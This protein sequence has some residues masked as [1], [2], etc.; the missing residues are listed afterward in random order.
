MLRCLGLFTATLC[1]LFTIGFAVQALDPS[2]PKWKW[3]DDQIEEQFLPFQAQGITPEMLDLT[4]QKTPGFK[5]TD[6]IYVKR[7]QIIDGEIHG[8]DGDAR[9]FLSTLIQLYPLP[10]LDVI[11]YIQDMIWTPELL[12]CPVLAT[13]T[14]KNKTDKIIFFPLQ[15]INYW[16]D[17]SKI[18]NDISK[19]SPWEAKYP[20]VFWRGGMND[21]DNPYNK[22]EW[23]TTPRGKLCYLSKYFPQFIDA[24]FSNM[25]RLE[26]EGIKND[27][28]QL[29]PI[30]TTS[31]EEH[32]R[33]KY[34]I[35][36][37]G[38]VASTPGCA[39][40]LLSNCA[41]F[42]QDSPYLL[43]YFSQLQ[44]WVHYIPVAQNL[45]DLFL[46]I[47]WAREHDDEVRQIAENGRAFAQEN[48]MPEHL[49]LYCYK[50]LKKYASLQRTRSTTP[51]PPVAETPPAIPAP[52]PDVVPAPTTP[53]SP[54]ATPHQTNKK[55]EKK[56]KRK[57]NKHRK[58]MEIYF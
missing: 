22:A 30:E 47:E 46:K 7:H 4:M 1:C 36:L 27:F 2:D 17:F 19:N 43:W 26:G 9:D 6:Y 56:K 37:D 31:W 40:K 12:A 25:V 38:S 32:L 58:S 42:K 34:L 10:D 24:T 51:V 44:P 54:A 21:Y 14:I 35:D 8:P 20:V 16:E 45:S 49:Y 15:L 23:T 55:K 29:F 53:V 13:C 48:I 41:L 28:Q 33:Y 18:V 11:I 52:L 50:V 5:Y 39:W 57:K 3:M